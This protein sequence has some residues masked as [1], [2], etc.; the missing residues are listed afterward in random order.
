MQFNA[1]AFGGRNPKLN[2][3]ATAGSGKYFVAQIGVELVQCF[4]ELAGNTQ[5]VQEVAAQ[6]GKNLTNKIAD[7]IIVDYL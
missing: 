7:Q 3:M 4:S 2:D 1:I 5:A 6:V